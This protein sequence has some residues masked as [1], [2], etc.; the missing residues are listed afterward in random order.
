MVSTLAPPVKFYR[1]DEQLARVGKAQEI[2]GWFTH[3]LEDKFKLA[4]Q[5]LRGVALDFERHHHFDSMVPADGMIFQYR[6]FCPAFLRAIDGNRRGW[7]G[8]GDWDD[9]RG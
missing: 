8:G 2:W 5:Q 1:V 7:R 6:E 3:L 9:G 4:R